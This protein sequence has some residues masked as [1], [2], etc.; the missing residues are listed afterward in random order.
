MN[1]LEAA[2]YKL[3][4]DISTKLEA[5]I[6]EADK[7]SL[8]AMCTTMEDWL[9]DDGMDA[10]KSVYEAKL[11][12]LNA[13]FAPGISREKEASLRPD[14]FAELAGAID[15]FNTFAASASDD[16]AHISTE[17]K[18]KVATECATAQAWLADVEAKIGS[19]AK[20]AD[21][22]VKAAEI[23]AKASALSAV[24]APIMSTPKPLPVEPEGEAAAGPKPD[25][26]DVD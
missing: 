25:N 5:Y 20:T 12:E 19:A 22:P 26:M 1:A 8:S 3:R 23:S 7:E 13:A 11:K 14:A 2:V 10:E 24:C 18:Q 9:Y 4:D 21:P 17:D 6:S 16:Y 15:K